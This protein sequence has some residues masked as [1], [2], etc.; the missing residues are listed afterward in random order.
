VHSDFHSTSSILFL[1]TFVTYDNV[2]Q[3]MLYFVVLSAFFIRYDFLML[4]R[5]G[6]D[7]FDLPYHGIHRYILVLSIAHDY[8][9]H[10]LTKQK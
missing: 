8:I 9:A 10:R 2:R 7:A 4:L 1:A 5:F 3:H 6:I